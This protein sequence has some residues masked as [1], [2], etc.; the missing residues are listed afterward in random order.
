[1]AINNVSIG[2]LW[3]QVVMH[4]IIVHRLRSHVV[5]SPIIFDSQDAMEVESG[6]PEGAA[7]P[8]VRFPAPLPAK[9]KPK[10]KPLDTEQWGAVSL[11]HTSTLSSCTLIRK[12]FH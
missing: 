4:P 1:M 10:P 2:N 6:P 8:I 12:R 5:P 7:P 3:S 11:L 9:R